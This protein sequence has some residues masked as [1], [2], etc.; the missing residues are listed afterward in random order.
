MKNLRRIICA[1]LITAFIIT[2]AMFAVACTPTTFTAKFMANGSEYKS[3]SVA[4]GEKLEKPEDPVLDG[5]VFEG[6]YDNAETTGKAVT[7]PVSVSSD[8]T[9]YAKLS[10]AYTVTLMDGTREMGKVTGKPGTVIN[11]NTDKT[12]YIFEGWYE[13]AGFA[14]P[15]TSMVIG[16]KNDTY[17]AKYSRVYTMSFETASEFSDAEL[18]EAITA[19]EGAAINVDDPDDEY[20]MFLGWYDNADFT[21]HPVEIPSEMPAKNTT[22]YAKLAEKVTVYYVRHKNDSNGMFNVSDFIKEEHALG[23]TITIQSPEDLPDFAN[24]NSRFIAWTSAPRSNGNDIMNTGSLELSEDKYSAG[25][26][27]YLYAQWAD[28]YISDASETA[29]VYVSATFFGENNAIYVKNDNEITGNSYITPA[30][31]LEF[32]FTIENG[33]NFI[34]MVHG[35]LRKNNGSYHLRD[36][37]GGNYVRTDRLNNVSETAELYLSGY[38]YAM[39]NNSSDNDPDAPATVN[40]R[41]G[42]FVTEGNKLYTK[43]EYFGIIDESI[44]TSTGEH[45]DYVFYDVTLDSQGNISK[46]QH[47]LNFRLNVVQDADI[48]EG[49][50]GSFL[51]CGAESSSVLE[52]HFGSRN[53]F[54]LLFDRDAGKETSNYIIIFDGYGDEARVLISDESG[55]LSKVYV[56]AYNPTGN[57]L[58]DNLSGELIIENGVECDLETK[59][60]LPNGETR[61]FT[62]ILTY[63]I[64]DGYGSFLLCD[65]DIAGTYTG[66][67]NISLKIDGYD[68]YIDVAE[69]KDADGTVLRGEYALVDEDIMVFNPADGNTSTGVTANSVFFNYHEKTIAP[70]EKDSE[71]F[72]VFNNK[73]YAY[74]GDK[75]GTAEDPVKV[76]D[77]VTTVYNGAF[78]YQ[79]NVVAV[80]L[81][82]VT[83]VNNNAFYGCDK[84]T[85]V[86]FTNVTNIGIQAFFGCSSLVSVELPKVVNIGIQAFAN[87]KALETVEI[88]SAIEEMGS[89]AFYCSSTKTGDLVIHFLGENAPSIGDYLI[90]VNSFD[91]ANGKSLL[92]RVKDV[93]VLK[94]FY[95]APTWDAYRSVVVCDNINPNAYFG[96]W[97]AEDLS[98]TIF[99]EA[100]MIDGNV[101]F[102]EEKDGVIT[103]Y[104]RVVNGNDITLEEEIVEF[105]DD[106]STVIIGSKVYKTIAEGSKLTFTD[107]EGNKLEFVHSGSTSTTDAKAVYT[108]VDGEPI[109][110]AIGIDNLAPINIVLIPEGNIL[111]SYKINVKWNQNGFDGAFTSEFRKWS[112]TCDSIMGMLGGSGNE[113]TIRVESKNELYVSCDGLESIPSVSGGTSTSYGQVSFKD[114]AVQAAELSANEMG[115]AL[116]MIFGFDEEVDGI[117]VTYVVSVTCTIFGD[118]GVY[119]VNGWYCAV[120][121]DITDETSGITIKLYYYLAG[122]GMENNPAEG[123]LVGFD[124]IVDGEI[125]AY[126]DVSTEEALLI[127]ITEGT[128]AGT[129]EIVLGKDEE[130]NVTVKFVKQ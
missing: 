110:S 58:E 106:K 12:D 83:T 95:A 52:S 129:Y 60:P 68:N 125:V 126:E 124:I 119:Q 98:A 32:S 99:N 66:E 72:V 105:S 87:T 113:L 30:N 78:A 21:G 15:V 82:N 74:L 45:Y 121:E 107:S 81:N 7:F 65:D 111:N 19:K 70:V 80:D 112:V 122:N 57:Y 116:T 50:Q 24:G 123:D 93:D 41:Y 85:S 115:Y 11:I 2:V 108:P 69:Y 43:G 14:T 40:V 63:S 18:P 117:I 13:D 54:F 61:S 120:T 31:D 39:E 101:V 42:N 64:Q 96:I 48:P 102:Y 71:G 17:Y 36:Y 118:Y 97:F 4:E 46:L 84:L 25:E 49:V 67:G 91:T 90:N 79:A 33:V 9:Y 73:L 27:I 94:K 109:V 37:E 28:E 38:Y 114:V 3:V 55:K 44:L 89:E 130:G 127:K 1:S 29:K 53:P 23:S 10:N 47:L 77:N 16:N 59:E 88:G 22:F 92:V 128:K 103:V 75:T 6:W 51:E 62:V 56:G 34:G 20:Y 5:Y 76:P 104:K 86:K 8:V 26:S 100:S 35:N